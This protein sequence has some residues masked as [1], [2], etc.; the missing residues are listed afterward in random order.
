MTAA[1]IDNRAT[2]EHYSL[3]KLVQ[4]S[5]AELDVLYEAGATPTLEALQG[6]TE[7][8]VLAGIPGLGLHSGHIRTLANLGWLPWKGKRFEA[9][10]KKHGQGKNRI[11]TG[12]AEQ[13]WFP[14]KTEIIS[15]LTGTTP[16]FSLDYDLPGNPW[17]I[18]QIRDDIRKI[19]DHLYLGT[20]NFRWRNHFHF[21]LYF[22]LAT[23][24]L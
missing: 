13:A 19:D 6:V 24:P 3:D 9:I 11:H 22:A 8:R 23:Q 17:L 18:R 2:S 7:G 5:K 1:T 15:P 16:V 12:W 20:A 10:N 4:L 14:F 21:V